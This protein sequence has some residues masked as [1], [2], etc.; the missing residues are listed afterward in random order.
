MYKIRL[1]KYQ[2]RIEWQSLR[3]WAEKK[4]NETESVSRREKYC[5][6]QLHEILFILKAIKKMGKQAQ[7]KE[8]ILLYNQ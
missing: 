6:I 4:F 5:A 2:R 1:Y 7:T 8:H 3:H